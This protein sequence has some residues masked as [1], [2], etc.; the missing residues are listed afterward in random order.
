V[1]EGPQCR[2]DPQPAIGG[3]NLPLQPPQGAQA[4]SRETDIPVPP[5]PRYERSLYPLEN[6]RKFTKNSAAVATVKASS[7]KA[8]LTSV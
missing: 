1:P 3:L 4:N 7:D 6:S 2:S 8:M 5:P